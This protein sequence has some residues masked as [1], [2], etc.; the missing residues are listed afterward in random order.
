MS[1]EQSN[2]FYISF[3][4]GGTGPQAVVSNEWMRKRR[5]IERSIE[6]WCTDHIGES[7]FPRWQS[8]YGT[9]RTPGASTIKTVG[10]MRGIWIYNDADRIAFKL[11]F[12]I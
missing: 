6:A 11:T 8:K 2:K 12:G 5:I 10:L 9:T 7:G 4:L 3:D 1:E